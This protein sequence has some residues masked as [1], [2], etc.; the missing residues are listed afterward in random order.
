M[1]LTLCETS[2]T[3]ADRK[4]YEELCRKLLIHKK[5]VKRL[6]KDNQLAVQESIKTMREGRLEIGMRFYGAKLKIGRH[7]LEYGWK[8]EPFVVS[9][10]FVDLMK[11]LFA[12]LKKKRLKYKQ[13]NSENREVHGYRYNRIGGVFTKPGTIKSLKGTVSD[14][15]RLEAVKKPFSFKKEN[16]VG[17]EIEMTAMCS[18]EYLMDKFIEDNLQSYVRIQSDSSIQRD[19]NEKYTYE[20]VF[21]AEET[22]IN[23]IVERVCKVISNKRVMGKANNSCGLH[24]H[25]DMRNRNVAECYKKLY[26]SQS[27][28]LNMLPMSRREGDWVKRY[29]KKNETGEW[30]DQPKDH[31]DHR[32]YAIN[33][34]AYL[35]YKT[36]E[37]RSHSGTVNPIKINSWIN[38]LTKIVN[39]S[40]VPEQ[41]LKSNINSFCEFFGIAPELKGYIEKR[42]KKFEDTKID[43]VK[44]EGEAA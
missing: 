31:H 9:K 7:N 17:V 5:N 2:W 37:L 18:K 44:D 23:S 6:S 11:K 40:K 28:L 12:D 4:E 24:V 10:I 8:E 39:T 35:K 13:M 43:T 15:H 36:L 34:N 19:G 41:H 3:E 32:Y 22:E 26:Y 20:I 14:D 25:L 16:Y 21:M 33:A 30:K 27:I 38:I 29:C 42:T 1:K